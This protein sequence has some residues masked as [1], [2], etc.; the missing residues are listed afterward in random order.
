VEEA[1]REP[2]QRAGEHLNCGEDREQPSHGRV[3][4]RVPTISARRP[5][6]S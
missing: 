5:P 2:E 4:K 3:F 6:R 1:G